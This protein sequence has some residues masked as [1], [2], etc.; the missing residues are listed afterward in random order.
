[1]ILFSEK[2][3]LGYKAQPTTEGG[4]AVCDKAEELLNQM[5]S[6]GGWRYKLGHGYRKRNWDIAKKY[7]ESTCGTFVKWVFQ[8]AGYLKPNTVISH[9]A[10]AEKTRD[11]FEKNT[12]NCTWITP[13]KKLSKVRDELLPGD[14]VIFPETIFIYAGYEK[15]VY[16]SYNCINNHRFK[17]CIKV[18]GARESNFLH[19]Y[20]V[21]C[22]VRPGDG[23]NINNY[24]ASSYSGTGTSA[25]TE[26]ETFQGALGQFFRNIWDSVITF[27]ENSFSERNDSSVMYDLNP[28]DDVTLYGGTGGISDGSMVNEP[29]ASS[30]K[31]FAKTNGSIQNFAITDLDSSPIV[32]LGC[33]PKEEPKKFT[34][35][36]YKNANSNSKGTNTAKIV[37]KAGGH[38][39]FSVWKN[40]ASYNIYTGSYGDLKTGHMY[41]RDYY[42]PKGVARTIINSTSESKSLNLARVGKQLSKISRHSAHVS[43]MGVDETTGRMVTV[44]GGKAT[45]WQLN[46]SDI[47]ASTKIGTSFSIKGGLNQG[48]CLCGDYYYMIGGMRAKD[49]VIACYDINSGKEV[50]RK[51]MNISSTTGNYEPEGIKIYNYN[52]SNKIFIAFN[53]GRRNLVF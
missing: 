25:D 1:M 19:K 53:V 21:I 38:Q 4:K 50:W 48:G 15:G 16:Y 32:W 45:V 35:K 17:E 49:M 51:N 3:V 37:L 27:F 11:A 6:M 7:R 33:N 24:N 36:I 31:R 34:V 23:G 12:V 5:H 10:T 43:S 20:K 8:E 18:E 40:G 9:K 13:N 28:E 52:G 29:N 44:V 42:N 14:C 46:M 2:N 26:S 47:K 22:I 41:G 30:V 39:C